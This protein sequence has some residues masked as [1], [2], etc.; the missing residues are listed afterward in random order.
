MYGVETKTSHSS[1]EHRMSLLQ[2]VSYE[3]SGHSKVWFERD[4][5]IIQDLILTIKQEL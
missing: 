2:A 5:K 4:F 1:H 3:E